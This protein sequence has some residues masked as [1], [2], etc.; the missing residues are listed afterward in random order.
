MMDKEPLQVSEIDTAG[1]VRH[2]RR[3]VRRLGFRQ[4]SLKV[5]RAQVEDACSSQTPGLK[6]EIAPS[7]VPPSA[8]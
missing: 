8:V 6:L 5:N 7:Y 4:I 1:A 2:H 3:R